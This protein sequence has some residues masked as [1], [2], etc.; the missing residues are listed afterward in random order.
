MIYGDTPSN[1]FTI[2]GKATNVPIELPIL[3]NTTTRRIRVTLFRQ[4]PLIERMSSGSFSK[5][6]TLGLREKA[7]TSPDTQPAAIIGFNDVNGAASME[8]TIV[9]GCARAMMAPI[10]AK[11]ALAPIH[12]KIMSFPACAPP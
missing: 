12:H 8:E 9:T 1:N 10:P 6:L 5:S 11:I 4:K 3:V 2:T 7:S